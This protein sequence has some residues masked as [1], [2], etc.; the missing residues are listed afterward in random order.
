MDKSEY[1]KLAAAILLPN[2]CGFI[3]G[4][5]NTK[6]VQ[7]WQKNL[8]NSKY[9]PPPWFF[10]P[11]WAGVYTCTGCASYLVWNEGNGLS[12]SSRLPLI[13]YGVQLA[14]NYAWIPSFFSRIDM[15]NVSYYFI[16]YTRF[17]KIYRTS[18]KL[19]K[20]SYLQ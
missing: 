5:I 15:N 11:I 9:S 6:T 13:F 4:K 2:T 10:A 3:S 8:K 18:I 16:F 1:A 19:V 12:G 20:K 7:S 14:M 17:I